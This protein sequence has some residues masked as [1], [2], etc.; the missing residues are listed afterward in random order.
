MKRPNSNYILAR[1]LILSRFLQVLDIFISLL[2]SELLRVILSKNLYTLQILKN[3]LFSYLIIDK[4]SFSVFVERTFIIWYKKVML[5]IHLYSFICTLVPITSV[6]KRYKIYDAMWILLMHIFCQDKD[7]CFY[8]KNVFS[9]PALV[10]M[11]N[12]WFI[13]LIVDKYRHCP[14][15]T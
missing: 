5:Y 13:W 3:F 15:E 10:M 7:N 8:I 9:S 14:T 12:I 4:R 6:E 1:S 2:A 11:H